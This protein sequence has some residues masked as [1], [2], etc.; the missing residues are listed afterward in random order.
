MD[1]VGKVQAGLSRLIWKGVKHA[2]TAAAGI[3]TALLLHKLNYNLSPEHQGA[4]AL[5]V[6]GVLGAGLK[7]LKDTFPKQLGWM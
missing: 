7:K 4:I 3:A 2:G 6:S 1:I 5:G